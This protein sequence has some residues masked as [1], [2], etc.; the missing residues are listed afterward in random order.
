MTR[1]WKH[2]M[3]LSVAIVES[4]IPP[5]LKLINSISRQSQITF[6]I[7]IVKEYN[8][9]HKSV[10]FNEQG[11]EYSNEVIFPINLLRDLAVESIDTSHFFICDI[12]AFP[13]KTLYDSILLHKEVLNDPKAVFILKLFSMNNRDKKVIECKNNGDCEKL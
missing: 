2:Q 3:I 12:D 10:F 9:E 7:Y 5:L 1:R 4:E 13:S 11:P 8:G 6:V